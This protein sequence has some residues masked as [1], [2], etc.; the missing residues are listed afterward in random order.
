VT[1]K[2][3]GGAI[4]ALDL[5]GATTGITAL[6]LFNFAWNQAPI[7]GWD[8]PYIIVTLILGCFL[9]PAFLYIELKVADDPLIPKDVFTSENA[10][11]LACVAL[12]WSSF[13]SCHRNLTKVMFFR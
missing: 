12:G 13:V 7:V 6:I 10:F 4:A 2:S 9:F 8:N 11:V 5:L 3:L 1:G